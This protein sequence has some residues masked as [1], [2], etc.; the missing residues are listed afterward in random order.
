[1]LKVRVGGCW[2]DNEVR[3]N[4]RPTVGLRSLNFNHFGLDLIGPWG[5]S[6]AEK[7]Q[8]GRGALMGHHATLTF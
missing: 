5:G 1:M 7:E 2:D 8:G 4:E 3:C 6:E